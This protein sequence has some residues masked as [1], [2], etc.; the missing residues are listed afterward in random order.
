MLI[1]RKSPPITTQPLI[2]E[3]KKGEYMKKNYLNIGLELVEEKEGK[4][5]KALIEIDIDVDENSDVVTLVVPK[6]YRVFDYL[7][8]EIAKSNFPKK[9]IKI[10]YETNDIVSVFDYLDFCSEHK[11]NVHV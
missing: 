2:E 3:N 7:I 9:K 10:V 8:E 6:P 5:G 11:K 1:K 4:N